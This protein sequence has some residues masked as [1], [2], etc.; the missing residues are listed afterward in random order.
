MVKKKI[1]LHF[2]RPAFSPWVGKIPWRREWLP[3]PVILLGEVHGPGGQQSVRMKQLDNIPD[4]MDIS[5]SR[6]Q[7]TV[8]DREAWCPAVHEVRKSWT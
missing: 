2:R 7:E 4:S 5:L 6:L 3:T 8:K 1:F